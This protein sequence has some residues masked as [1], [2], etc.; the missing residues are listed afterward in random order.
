MI[1]VRG[2]QQEVAPRHGPTVLRPSHGAAQSG[3]QVVCMTAPPPP[4]PPLRYRPIEPTDL[5]RVK[6][7]NSILFPIKYADE[8]YQHALACG[9]VTQLGEAGGRRDLGGRRPPACRRINS[10]A[11]PPPPPSV[12]HQVPP[13]ACSILWQ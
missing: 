10:L 4:A 7:L 8:V 1:G 3:R 2:S 9:D 5:A 11:P 6:L 13:A 12:L